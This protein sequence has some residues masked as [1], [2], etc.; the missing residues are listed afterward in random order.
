MIKP[1]ADLA[2]LSADTVVA[3]V[4]NSGIQFLDVPLALGG[5]RL[6]RDWFEAP[7]ADGVAALKPL[8]RDPEDDVYSYTDNGRPVQVAPDDEGFFSMNGNNALQPFLGKWVPVP[9]LQVET[10][11]APGRRRLAAGPQNWARLRIVELTG[12]KN[13]ALTHRAVFAFDTTCAKRT[14]EAGFVVPWEDEP[15]RFA[16]GTTMPEV[17][18]L[19][20]RPW[21][22]GWLGEM[23]RERNANGQA[24]DPDA[25]IGCRHFAAYLTLLALLQESRA[26]PSV[27][28]IDMVAAQKLPNGVIDVELVLDLGNSRSCGFL[29]ERTPGRAAAIAD[30]Y[31]LCLRDLSASEET[32]DQ[33]FESRVEF[34]RAG[35]GR[36]EWSLQSGHG[37]AFDWPGP[38][39]IGPEA[40]RLSTLN[41]GNEGMTG[42][43]SPKRYL[44]DERPVMSPW[45]VNPATDRE[46][47]IRGDFLLRVAEDGT[48]LSYKTNRSGM[49]VRQLFSRASMFT[50]FL[51]EVLLQARGQ[52]N[53]FAE[54]HGKM[55][56]AAPRRLARLILT[57]PA[58]MP[59]E[60]V[61][62]VEDRAKAAACL[63]RD[64]TDPGGK[65]LEIEAR[66]DEAT[67]TQIVY[68]Y[69]QINHAYRDAPAYFELVGR[70]RPDVGGMAIPSLRVASI[71]VGGGT[72]DLAIYTYSLNDRV[73]MPREEFRE[74]FRLAGDDVLE[75]VVMRHVMPAIRDALMEGGLDRSRAE[76]FLISLFRVPA[77]T[78][79]ERL[80]RRLVVNHV[81]VPAALGLLGDYES[82]DPLAD[83][84]SVQRRLGDLLAGRGA[85]LRVVTQGTRGRAREPVGSR[86]AA[87]LDKRAA[88]AGVAGFGVENVSI[89][90]D[91]QAIHQTV[92]QTLRNA[93]DPMTE[94]VRRFDC[95]V[96]LL[97]GRGA[98]WPALTDLVTGS[99]A[100]EPDRIQPMHRYRVGAWYPYSDN[101]GRIFDPKTTVAVGA[102]ICRLLRGGQLEN[103]ALKDV[104]RM[105]STARY[106]GLMESD[107][108]IR[109]NRILFSR[110]PTDPDEEADGVAERP[111][112]FS[113]RCFLGYKQF[114]T[115]RWP[116]SPLY[117]I[118]FAS[119]DRASGLRLPLQLTLRRTLKQNGN[120]ES[121]TEFEIDQN[122]MMQ[123]SERPGEPGHMVKAGSVVMSLQTLRGEE[124]S[125]W[126]DTG[127]FDTLDSML[128]SLVT[129][130]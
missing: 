118:E 25:E 20:D 105:R 12:E 102:M 13:T 122:N 112:P 120:D 92:R 11:G 64:L 81:L 8:R 58:A 7:R 36:E 113:G 26:V 37:S 121:T 34:A 40:V 84:G 109:P 42:L 55:D 62:K 27:R 51:L 59:T 119:A 38:V 9:F 78:E 6:S 99:L 111:L 68:L 66:L 18:W 49:A 46:G 67:A 76:Q 110:L 125:Y 35:L 39:R 54:R 79:P 22:R 89:T 117:R 116:A 115:E 80:A 2:P 1:A 123:A 130:D 14:A 43:S 21:M 85:G 30:S 97:T 60:E 73:V 63:L 10:D 32:S 104:F 103:L 69:D 88:D 98:R 33:P 101:T 82:W 96:L 114:L 77:G 90:L 108:R 86:A 93:I 28:L 47:K 72:T 24:L 65:P 56:S 129:R 127:R 100:I 5:L 61:K 71:D 74:G 70:V 50:F 52:V 3:L 87:W 126:L 29:I 83:T 124:G 23:Y 4:P 41:Q 91:F 128:R 44:W 45:R 106:V 57:L 48:V 19:L 53:S 16:L 17:S 107:Q 75:T 15:A 94:I 95:D 31:R